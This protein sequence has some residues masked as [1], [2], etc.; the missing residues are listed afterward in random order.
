M[1]SSVVDLFLFK[2]FRIFIC[3]LLSFSPSVSFTWQHSV[4]LSGKSWLSIQG[5]SCSA[6]H[7]CLATLSFFLNLLIETV[8]AEPELS[9]IECIEIVVQSNFG[10]KFLWMVCRMAN[11]SLKLKWL[12]SSNLLDCSI[13]NDWT[14]SKFKTATVCVTLAW[15]KSL[16]SPCA[17][18][19][20]PHLNI[21]D[22]FSAKIKDLL[23]LSHYQYQ[24]TRK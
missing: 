15:G 22:W 20:V 1:T 11:A 5:L 24:N 13:W 19:T 8:A 6:N 10:N 16:P 21:L 9:F 18:V 2:Y 7:S 12:D 14:S 17:F 4:C 3:F 23:V